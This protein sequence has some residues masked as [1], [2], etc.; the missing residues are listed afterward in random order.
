[1]DNEDVINFVELYRPL[2]CKQLIKHKDLE[3][4]VSNSCI[5]QLLCEES[6]AR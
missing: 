1:M 2:T 3:V 4:N 6:R 5:A